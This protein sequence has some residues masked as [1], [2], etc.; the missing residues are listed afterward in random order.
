MKN[1]WEPDEKREFVK[2]QLREYLHRNHYRANKRK[3]GRYFNTY[4]FLYDTMESMAIR[5]VIKQIDEWHNQDPIDIV[6]G[7]YSW[8]DDHL[9]TCP[10]TAV[11]TQSMLSAYE[12]ALS[13]ILLYLREEVKE[14]EARRWVFKN[15]Q[16]AL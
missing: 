2:K 9:A 11:K 13:D 16:K 4:A 6:A 3:P 7:R 10:E 14:E 8:A 12:N 5:D 15:L 1:L